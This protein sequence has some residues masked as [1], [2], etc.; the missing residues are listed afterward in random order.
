MYRLTIVGGGPGT[1]EYLLPAAKE[2]IERAGWVFADRR[3]LSFIS[4]PRV[5]VFGDIYAAVE[6][7]RGRLDVCDVTVLVSGSPVFYSLTGL[8]MKQIPEAQVDIIPGIGSLE[9]LAA[10]CLKTT[11]QAVFL[12]LHGRRMAPEVLIGQIRQ[13]PQCY[14][15]CDRMHTPAWLADRLCENGLKDVEM[16]V[17]SRLGYTDERIVMASAC[18]ISGQTFDELSVVGVFNASWRGENDMNGIL[19]TDDAFMRD[20]V[21]MT[22]A[23]VRWCILG[24]L[25]L[26][27]DGI[28]WDIG[29]GTGSVTVE[30]AR[31]MPFG[32]IY[33]VEKNG[34]AVNLIEKNVEKHQLSNVTVIH[35]EA[36]QVMDTLPKPTHVFVGGVGKSLK[37]VLKAIQ[38]L[39]GDIRVVVSAV[40]METAALALECLDQTW[41]DVE[42]T[43]IGISHGRALGSYHL[44]EPAN[45]V[46][47][48]CAGTQISHD[49]VSDTDCDGGKN[50][51]F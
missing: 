3:Y 6:Q 7:I 13:H 44:L 35:G 2:A 10:R 50:E 32:H 46:T 24:K 19:L 45:P 34:R 28:L 49:L 38:K 51:Q 27:K 15:L 4:H 48:F 26:K 29:A 18:K 30:C 12:S 11:E 9:Y 22:R 39:G 47:L 5:E 20:Q 25:G 37:P 8:L 42:I 17:G 14:F 41:K 31:H 21:P 1:P 43:Q 40:T 16:A 23:E 33:A 36:S